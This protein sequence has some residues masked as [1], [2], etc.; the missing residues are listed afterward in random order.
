FNH[1]GIVTLDGSSYGIDVLLDFLIVH[2]PCVGADPGDFLG[3]RRGKTAGEL[4]LRI[5]HPGPD[6]LLILV[7]HGAPA[8]R[9]LS[10]GRAESA[11]VRLHRGPASRFH[12]EDAEIYG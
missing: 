1:A 5:A 4:R 6:F 10:H 12:A 2:D 11:K 9:W 8:D 7:G 3:S